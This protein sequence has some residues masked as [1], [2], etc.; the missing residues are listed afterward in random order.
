MHR[1][2]TSFCVSLPDPSGVLPSIWKSLNDSHSHTPVLGFRAMWA[3]AYSRPAYAK[4]LMILCFN[5]YLCHITSIN[6]EQLVL[7]L[8]RVSVVDHFGPWS[9]RYDIYLVL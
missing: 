5:C 4:P 8:P 3:A 1:G 9:P 7:T 2:K 6:H